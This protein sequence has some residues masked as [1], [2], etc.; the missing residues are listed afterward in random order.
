VHLE[1]FDVEHGACA[2]VT[3]GNG[4]RILI[5]G[6]WHDAGDLTQGME[7]TGEIDYA[8]FSLAERLHERKEDTALY[9]RVLEEARWGLD[10]VLK[11]S[12]GDGFRNG[13]SINSR[14][15]NSIIGDDDDITATA[16]NNPMTNFE[17]AAVEALASRV[18]KDSDPTLSSYALKMARADWRFAIAGMAT[19]KMNIILC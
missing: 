14:R 11:T 2:L 17:A 5:N 9:D 18:L 10:W 4:K 12:F 6:G 13:G 3:T 16:R 19:L 7:N 8:L 15:T 1:I